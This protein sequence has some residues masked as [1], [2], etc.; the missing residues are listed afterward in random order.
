MTNEEILLA[1]YGG[2]EGFDKANAPNT[3]SNLG[4]AANT[5]HEV[6]VGV[7]RKLTTREINLKR[8]A[9]L[10]EGRKKSDVV[11]SEK[12]RQGTLSKAKVNGSQGTQD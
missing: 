6:A 2:S 3:Q 9:A 7:A 4:V 5:A 12:S 8:L 1:F 10:E 11:K